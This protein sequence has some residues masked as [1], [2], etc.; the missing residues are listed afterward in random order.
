M[1]R[2]SWFL[3]VDVA[4][5]AEDESLGRMCILWVLNKIP[6]RPKRCISCGGAEV[7]TYKHFLYCSR[8][9]RLNRSVA[10]G[11]WVFQLMLDT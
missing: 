2:A 10:G 6:G 4:P 11:S 8:N 7:R 9:L 1:G 3:Y 5:D